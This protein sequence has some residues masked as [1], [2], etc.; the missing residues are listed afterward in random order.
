MNCESIYVIPLSIF[1]YSNIC[2]LRYV[3]ILFYSS[4]F[5]YPMQA[6][7][8]ILSINQHCNIY[9]NTTKSMSY[10]VAK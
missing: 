8:I 10:V 5:I 1:S 9:L 4:L 2:K 3:P 7:T 6:T